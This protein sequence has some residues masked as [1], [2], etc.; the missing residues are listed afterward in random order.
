M[1]IWR[2]RI[3]PKIT[4]CRQDS[5]LNLCAPQANTSRPWPTDFANRTAL[6]TTR[7]KNQP[8]WYHVDIQIFN[9]TSC[10]FIYILYIS[11]FFSN[12]YLAISN[13]RLGITFYVTLYSLFYWR[14]ICVD[15]YG[16]IWIFHLFINCVCTDG[17][18]YK[19]KDIFILTQIALYLA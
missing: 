8:F 11:Y 7:K 12:V 1:L 4:P 15:F 3:T 2:T 19:I 13:G 18:T 17:L 16:N 6:S 10:T 5:N 9:W 14:I